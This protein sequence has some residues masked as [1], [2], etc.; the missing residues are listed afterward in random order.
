MNSAW[1]TVARFDSSGA[2][3]P[4]YRAKDQIL[5]GNFTQTQLR[6]NAH[7]IGRKYLSS[8]GLV[9][10]FDNDILA[11]DGNAHGLVIE[12]VAALKGAED[13]NGID[14]TPALPAL[15]PYCVEA[16]CLYGQCSLALSTASATELFTCEFWLQYLYAENQQLFSIGSEN[17]AVAVTISSQEP[18]AVVSGVVAWQDENETITIYT[19]DRNP[20]QGDYVYLTAEACAA[21]DESRYTVTEIDTNPDYTVKSIQ[22]SGALADIEYNYISGDSDCNFETFAPEIVW[23]EDSS[24]MNRTAEAF[25]ELIHTANGAEERISLES[26]GVALTEYEWGKFT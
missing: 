11:Q 10:H 8:D 19:Q 5:I 7:D 21:G 15:A 3:A 4:S 12:G 26:L 17:E 14:F 16:R 9:W 22:V 13:S 25:N 1:Y 2:I 24:L 18:Y 23:G 6:R 20:S